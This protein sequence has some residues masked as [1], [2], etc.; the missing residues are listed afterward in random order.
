MSE[1][2]PKKETYR[3]PCSWECYGEVKVEA[4]TLQEAVEIAYEGPL[5]WS[6]EY[7]DGSFEVDIELAEFYLMEDEQ[8][9]NVR[10]DEEVIE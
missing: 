3:I 1:R 8:E 2:S 4:E 7:V 5:P 9:R 6:H 10:K